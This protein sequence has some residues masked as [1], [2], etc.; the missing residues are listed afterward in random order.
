MTEDSFNSEHKRLIVLF[1]LPAVSKTE[2]RISALFRKNLIGDGFT[3]MQYSVYTRFCHSN[4]ILKT[5]I[6][7]VHQYVPD[8]GCV[9]ILAITEKQFENMEIL[10]GTAT[11]TEQMAAQQL[12]FL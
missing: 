6:A 4:A 5:H 10:G 7:R 9:R 12:S 2:K 3:M 11:Q 1:D 8:T